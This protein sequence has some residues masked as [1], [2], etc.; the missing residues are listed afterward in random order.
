M[1]QSP[2]GKPI[3]S[4]PAILPSSVLDEGQSQEAGNPSSRSVS[5]SRPAK[6]ASEEGPP[7]VWLQRVWLVIYVGFCIEL[8]LWL[9]VAPWRQVWT[10]NN[11]VMEYPAVR[12]ILLNY[13]VRGIVT[14]LGIIDLGLGISAAV[15]YREKK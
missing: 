1:E 8:G 5:A 12:H 10:N 7:A 2:A 15:N 14:G 3:A 4:E 6:L 13:F 9:I 11:L